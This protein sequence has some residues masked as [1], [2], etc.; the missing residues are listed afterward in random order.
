LKNCKKNKGDQTNDNVKTRLVHTSLTDF[1]RALV[2]VVNK[3][4]K[5]AGIV[6]IVRIFNDNEEKKDKKIKYVIVCNIYT[7]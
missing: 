6:E 3:I 1:E 5:V 2:F 7:A 4:F